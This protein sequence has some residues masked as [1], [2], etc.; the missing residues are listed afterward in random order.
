[1]TATE[2]RLPRRSSPVLRQRATFYQLLLEKEGAASQLLSLCSP[3]P[4]MNCPTQKSVCCVGVRISHLS[5]KGIAR[6]L[7][8][9]ANYASSSSVYTIH[10]NAEQSRALRRCV[11]PGQS[12]R[13]GSKPNGAIDDKGAVLTELRG[14]K[15]GVR[16][17]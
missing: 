16:S 15:S 12:P 14:A 10:M 9:I 4:L 8:A 13:T 7:F 6:A 5:T 17:T 11:V 3:L 2:R 1:M